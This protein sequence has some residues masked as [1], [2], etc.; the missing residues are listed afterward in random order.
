MLNSEMVDHSQCDLD[1]SRQNVL[2][3]YSFLAD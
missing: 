2:R 3:Q 1:V